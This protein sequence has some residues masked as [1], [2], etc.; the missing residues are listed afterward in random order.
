[1]G[2]F[3]KRAAYWIDYYF[4]GRRRR[5]KIGSSFKLAQEVL[6][7][8]KTQIAE[9]KFFPERLRTKATFGE[10]AELYWKQQ[11]RH[12]KNHRDMRHMIDRLLGL[13]GD[14]PLESVTSLTVQEIRNKIKETASAA[15]AN[16]YHSLLRSI[17]YRAI[18][19][20]K[21]F[22]KN[23]AAI[24]KLEK[25]STGRTRYLSE[26]EVG[27]LL[28][29]CYP[30]IYPIILCA[31]STGMRRG[32]ILNLKWDDVN[33]ENKMI[34]I[35]ESK[36]GRP[37]EIPIIQKLYDVLAT[38]EK[39]KEKVFQVPVITLRKYFARAL[40]EANIHHFRFHDLRHTFASHF[41]MKTGD[42]PTLQ[43]ILGHQSP[44]MTQRYAHLASGHLRSAMELLGARW[45]PLWTPGLSE[46][47]QL[48]KK[49]S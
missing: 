7:K 36:S 17:I 15:R 1:M 35:L 19:W 32:E 42:L 11:G 16:R 47:N 31:L 46:P 28:K 45:T 38:L 23:P 14:K 39:G 49:A 18:E 44:A 2:V 13:L 33:L 10:V 3:K 5:E 25:E 27:R 34:Y 9:K 43:K 24:T 29:V 48:S 4:E 22:G 41:V 6:H 40:K 30:R 12:R 26:E 8:R 20:G 37:R 21:F